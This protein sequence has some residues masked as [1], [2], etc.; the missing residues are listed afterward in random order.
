MYRPIT[1]KMDDPIRYVYTPTKPKASSKAAP[2]VAPYIP[3][4]HPPPPPLPGTI[5]SVPSRQPKSLQVIA[6]E[7][8]NTT[9]MSEAPDYAKGS[10]GSSSDSDAVVESIERDPEPEAGDDSSNTHEAHKR[11]SPGEHCVITIIPYWNM[12]S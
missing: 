10:G 1:V 7:E 2:K 12:S 5:H 4:F 11:G 8:T 3:L 9:G 6:D